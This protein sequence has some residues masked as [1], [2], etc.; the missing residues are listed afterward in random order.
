MESFSTLWNRGWRRA[1][2]KKLI[3][4][5]GYVKMGWCKESDAPKWGLWKILQCC[6]IATMTFGGGENLGRKAN[7]A[8]EEIGRK[9]NI[10]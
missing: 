3:E 9:E 6:E 1:G 7:K 8:Q 4:S 5:M 2:G 10:V